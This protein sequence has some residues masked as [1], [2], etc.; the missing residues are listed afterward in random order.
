MSRFSDR[1]WSHES[2]RANVETWAASLEQLLGPEFDTN[3]AL[4]DI[5]EI[6]SDARAFEI[7][8]RKLKAYV[9]MIYEGKDTFGHSA[10]YD[11]PVDGVLMHTCSGALIDTTAHRG[12]EVQLVVS[13]AI[14]RW[15][16]SL[17]TNY[18]QRKCIVKM[19][20]LTSPVSE[21][22]SMHSAPIPGDVQQR[23]EGASTPQEALANMV[24]NE[25]GAK[26]APSGES[27]V[28]EYVQL[29]H[30]V[31]NDAI[32]VNSTP[33]K[34]KL[35]P[36]VQGPRLDDHHSSTNSLAVA[37]QSAPAVD[38]STTRTRPPRAADVDVRKTRSK[39]QQESNEQD[40]EPRQ[41]AKF[42]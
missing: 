34:T 32:G 41:G 31:K 33:K 21:D 29:E 10:R 40:S 7:T 28:R 16:N 11:M 1:N 4:N 36:R 37:E 9:V 8:R 20:V 17:G 2:Y 27:D 22:A 6:V 39:A 12:A 35:V 15:G 25:P 13:P 14:M 42:K 30:G 19:D 23:G 38:S 3:S 18:D 5:S 24:K 26:A